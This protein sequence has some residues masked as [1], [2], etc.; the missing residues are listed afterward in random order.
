MIRVSAIIP[1]YNGAATV[2]DAIRSALAQTFSA[3]EIIVVDDG[4]TDSTPAVLEQ[5]GDRIR[6]IRRPNGGISA[7]RNQ[8]AAA[9]AGEY[10]AFLDADDLWE[11]Q[12]VERCA[13]ALDAHPECVMA[14]AN[15]ALVDSDGRDLGARLIGSG[16][17]H[18]PTLE[19]MLVRLW[20][21]M[22]SAVMVRRSAYDT[23]GGFCEEFRSYGFEDVVFW[24]RL[25]ELGAF[26]F[27]PERLVRWRFALYPR[28][29][30]E[31][32]NR[33]EA[34]T[35]FDQ[36]LR[37]RYGV[38]AGVMIAGRARASRSILGYIGL[39]ALGRGDRAAAREAFRRALKLDPWRM[40]N[41]MRY[42]RTYLPPALARA[43]SGRTGAAGR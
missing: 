38:S 6:V 23:V 10:L 34:V 19:E 42:L 26:R 37:E 21:I 12:M 5:F 30:K 36:I 17:D 33:P 39:R 20:P 27:V 43:L 4:S 2:A 15:L 18:A 22:P 29:L 7:A 40:R 28:P 25:R 41:L 14:F 1:V 11:P 31:A 32:W 13:A 9:A 16:F 24:L 35:L 3:L 8:G